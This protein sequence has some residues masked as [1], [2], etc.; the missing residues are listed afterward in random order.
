MNDLQIL[1]V[2][3]VCQLMNCS[4]ATIYRWEQEGKLPFK[5]LR[6]GP[7]KVGFRRSDVKAFLEEQTE[8]A[9]EK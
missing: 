2:K 7:N 6:I 8:E 1:T 3:D 5:K 4:I 9:A